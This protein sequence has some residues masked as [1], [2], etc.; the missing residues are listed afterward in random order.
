MRC[1]A[2]EIAHEDYG[3]IQS[4]IDCAIVSIFKDAQRHGTRPVLLERPCF[5][6]K[7]LRMEEVVVRGSVVLDVLKRNAGSGHA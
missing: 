4:N 5:D 1:R 2:P 6:P 3:V 7:K